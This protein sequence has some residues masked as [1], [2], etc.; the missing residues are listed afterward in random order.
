MRGTDNLREYLQ[1]A[2]LPKMMHNPNSPPMPLPGHKS[3][4]NNLKVRPESWRRLESMYL[5]QEEC[6]F[7]TAVSTWAES[8]IPRRPLEEDDEDP[9]SGVSLTVPCPN[10]SRYEIPLYKE[11]RPDNIARLFKW[12]DTY[13]L[14]TVE[15]TMHLLHPELKKWRFSLPD[16]YHSPGDINIFQHFMWKLSEE[17]IG[18]LNPA[19]LRVVQRKQVVIAFQPPWVLSPQD[20]KAFVRC[21][22]YPTYRAPGHAYPTE[23]Q[24]EERLW[25]RLW[26]L[27]V[28]RNTPWFVLT[29]YHQWVF[30]R[31]SDRW[32]A[33][34]ITDIYEWNASSPT[35]IECLAFWTANAMDLTNFALPQVCES[36]S[37]SMACQTICTVYDAMVQGNRAAIA[38]YHL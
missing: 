8:K 5:L 2:I 35:I 26:D 19:G 25:G 36:D 16:D 32:T 18:R 24:S 6:Q 10:A 1:E 31:F 3:H 29:S 4:L 7:A 17:G 38:L 28:H 9:V 37:K 13:P 21:R 20:M 33:A 14:T 34:H 27:C 30:G 12:I 23:L 22:S 15:R 11:T